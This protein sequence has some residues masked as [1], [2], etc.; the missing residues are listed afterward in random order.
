MGNHARVNNFLKSLVPIMEADEKEAQKS[1]MEINKAIDV[2]AQ[3]AEGAS[4]PMKE[5]FAA[6]MLRADKE[7]AALREKKDD[8]VYETET[9]IKAKLETST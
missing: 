8:F 7:T 3:F 4:T 2:A 1:E 9:N 5:E 6:F